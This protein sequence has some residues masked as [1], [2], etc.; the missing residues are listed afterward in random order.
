MQS[1]KRE[2]LAWR[3]IKTWGIIVGT[4]FVIALAYGIVTAA[5]HLF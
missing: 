2:G 3:I 5:L 1:H 4:L